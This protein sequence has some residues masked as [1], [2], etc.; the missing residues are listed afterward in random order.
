MELGH[1]HQGLTALFL[2]Y[3][4]PRSWLENRS[5]SLETVRKREILS[6]LAMWLT[7]S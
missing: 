4:S 5:Q 7:P 1:E 6:T 2:V 3:F